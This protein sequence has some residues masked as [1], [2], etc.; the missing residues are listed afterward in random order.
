MVP[1]Q[2]D[3]H[4]LVLALLVWGSLAVIG[5]I[6]FRFMSHRSGQAPRRRGP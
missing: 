3:R 1:V 4:L 2:P 5:A 6:I